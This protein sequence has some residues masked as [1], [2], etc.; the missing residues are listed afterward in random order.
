MAEL[1]AEAPLTKQR[2]R[3][4]MANLAAAVNVVTTD[5]PAGR[6]GFI[7]TTGFSITRAPLFG[8]TKNS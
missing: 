3:D 7:S 1:D 5:G 2:Y 6:A 4:A 8:S